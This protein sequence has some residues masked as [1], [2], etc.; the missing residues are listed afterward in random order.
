MVQSLT[1]A[2]QQEHAQFAADL[3]ATLTKPFEEQRKAMDTLRCGL[4]AMENGLQQLSK[5]CKN[6]MTP[7]HPNNRSST[8]LKQRWKR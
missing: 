7:W 3:Q 6:M 2:A 5:Q 8:N 1:D 4:V